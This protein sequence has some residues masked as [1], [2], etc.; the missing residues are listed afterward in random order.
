MSVHG[1]GLAGG[2]QGAGV[3]GRTRLQALS[4]ADHQSADPAADADEAAVAPLVANV[5]HQPAL[6]SGGELVLHPHARD[7]EGSV[8]SYHH[9]C[10]PSKCRVEDPGRHYVVIGSFWSSRVCA[11]AVRIWICA[12][13]RVNDSPLASWPLEP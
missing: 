4:G 5:S 7:I 6:I 10:I 2:V 3:S 8:L 1:A 9:R 11:D 13:H 12:Q